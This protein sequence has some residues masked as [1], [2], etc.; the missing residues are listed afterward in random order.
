MSR[1]RAAAAQ[2]TRETLQ[3]FVQGLEVPDS[4]KVRLRH[5]SS[6][7]A[8]PPPPVCAESAPSA[9]AGGSA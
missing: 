7:A 6:R 1:A 8:A 5:M 2:V 9:L 3:K 4:A